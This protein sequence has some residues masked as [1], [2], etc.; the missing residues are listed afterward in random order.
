MAK[1][2]TTTQSCRQLGIS[3][4]YV[5]KLIASGKLSARKL[6]KIWLIPAN[7]VDARMEKKN[8]G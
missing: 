5:Y 1:E 8:V 2:L 4:D 6:N 7:E 3:I